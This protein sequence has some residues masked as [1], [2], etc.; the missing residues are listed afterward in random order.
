MQELFDAKSTIRS[1]VETQQR[2]C[3]ALFKKYGQIEDII[4]SNIPRS[5]VILD[6]N[7][8]WQFRKHGAGVE[9]IN[10]ETK[11]TIDAHKYIREC[12]MCIDSWRLHTYFNSKGIKY[13]NIESFVFKIDDEDSIR[14]LE[15]YLFSLNI[16]KTAQ[17]NDTYVLNFG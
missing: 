9:F 11:E 3:D 15:K 8:T 12:H 7:S 6:N 2:L 10:T 4:L 17:D 14:E 5:G 1:Y 13:I 16:L